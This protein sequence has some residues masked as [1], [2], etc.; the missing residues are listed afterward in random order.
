MWRF[1]QWF[2]RAWPL[3]ATL[4]VIAAHL[5]TLSIFSQQSEGVNKSFSIGLQVLG[6]LLVLDSI[7]STLGMLRGTTIFRVI[8]E[9]FLSCP[10]WSTPR[11][12]EGAG[13]ATLSVTAS[14]QGRVKRKATA[15]P[16]R[17]AELEQQMDEM[18]QDIG[19][20]EKALRKLI[21]D[22]KTELSDRVQ[23]GEAAIRRVD[24]KVDAT[25]LGTIKQQVFGVVIAIYG[26][27]LG[28]LS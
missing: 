27:G 21:S 23:K 19:R 10:I 7:N 15:I 13:I 18:Y 14:G 16:D 1:Y 3:W 17:V 9:W 12:I 26:A 28:Y 8:A 22:T 11:T 5:F 25:A 4:F 6:G 24:G 20:R 2:F